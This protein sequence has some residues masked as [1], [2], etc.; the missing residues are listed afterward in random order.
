MQAQGATSFLGRLYG[1]QDVAKALQL[2]LMEEPEFAILLEQSSSTGYS[3]EQVA[4]FRVQLLHTQKIAAVQH[5]LAYARLRK[6]VV[7]AQS[8]AELEGIR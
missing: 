5:Q 2:T 6:I 1:G 3:I 8:V 4:L 7:A